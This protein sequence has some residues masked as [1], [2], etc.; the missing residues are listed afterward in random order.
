MEVAYYDEDKHELV[1]VLGIIYI[2]AVVSPRIKDYVSVNKPSQENPVDHHQR[3]Q[4][5]KISEVLE[6]P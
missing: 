3:E 5:V 4:W 1:Q 2:L 6:M